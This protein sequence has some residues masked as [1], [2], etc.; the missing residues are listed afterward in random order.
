MIYAVLEQDGNV[1]N[2][3]EKEFVSKFHKSA[4]KRVGKDGCAGADV[5]VLKH[6][7]L[8][9]NRWLVI[10][11]SGIP[12]KF[13]Q[14]Q[15]D[16][17]CI[18]LRFRSKDNLKKAL[19]VLENYE[20]KIVDNYTISA[21]VMCNWVSAKL[22]VGPK[23]A[24]HLYNRVHGSQK[25]VVEAVDRLSVLNNV[26]MKAIDDLVDELGTVT[27]A[28]VAGYCI[29]AD[30]RITETEALNFIYQ[31]RYASKW[32][33]KSMIATLELYYAVYSL[34]DNGTLT[35]QNFREFLKTTDDKNF[36][37]C[38][39]YRLRKMIESHDVV[40]TELIYYTLLNVRCMPIGL[41]GIRF[42]I[43]IIKAGGNRECL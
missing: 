11:D 26:T 17:N 8:F 24:K 21:E 15:P 39:E 40:S 13:E 30:T 34:M 7:P 9:G 19:T 16:D 33:K 2:P 12:K 38:S 20:F 42:L 32:L 37:L 25:Y 3:V 41:D 29:G 27:V 22:N 10:C 6:P 14:L 4:V 23:V 18:F 43:G 5:S 28:Q 1:I 31:F 35:L 36:K